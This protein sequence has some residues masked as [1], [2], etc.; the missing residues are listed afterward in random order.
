MTGDLA[1]PSCSPSPPPLS[2]TLHQQT[3]SYGEERRSGEEKRGA[4]NPPSLPPRVRGTA[5]DAARF[6]GDPEGKLLVTWGPGLDTMGLA[7][8]ETGK[9]LSNRERGSKKKG[10]HRA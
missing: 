1:L 7:G 8:P 10:K 2:H 5:G 9:I 6:C 4:N 3:Q